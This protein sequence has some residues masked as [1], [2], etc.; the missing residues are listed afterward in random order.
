MRLA[1]L[2]PILLLASSVATACAATSPSI[3]DYRPVSQSCRDKAGHELTAIRSFTRDGV[4]SLLLADPRTFA[5][6]TAPATDLRCTDAPAAPNTPLRQ[7][8][9]ELTAPPYRLQNHGLTHA[10]TKGNGEFLTVDLCPSSRPF[11]RG[12]FETVE[13]LPQQKIGPVPVAVSITGTWLLKHP[14]ELAWLKEQQA[15]GRLA[16]TWVNHSLTHPY[17]PKAPLDRTFLLT[18]GLDT[19]REILEEE[20]L[21]LAN[22]ITPSVFF[23][24]P[25]LVADGGLITKLRRLSLIPLGADAWL[26]K[27]EVPTAG[28]IILVQ[29][30]GNEPA[31][32]RRL[33]PLLHEPG[34]LYLL[35]LADALVP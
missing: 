12:M 15:K 25:G 6:S 4:P 26:A 9:T 31:G 7:E 34:R 3:T 33:L 10:R 2:L 22:G 27:G 5:T 20:R 13:N 8:I 17:K 30:N 23:R 18:P 29:G 28:S 32:I 21:M 19:D 11:E 24:F 14:T 35:P 16:I 1:H